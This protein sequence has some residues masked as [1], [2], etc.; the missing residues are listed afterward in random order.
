MIC[1]ERGVQVRFIDDNAYDKVGDYW[2]VRRRE[3]EH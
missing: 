2:R 1:E 3:D